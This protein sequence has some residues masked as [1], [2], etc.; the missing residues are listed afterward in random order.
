M[1]HSITNCSHYAGPYIPMTH[2]RSN[3]MFIPFDPLPS[4]RLPSTPNPTPLAAT[5][6]FS[7]CELGG[8]GFSDSTYK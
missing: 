2:L 6:L 7:V 8:G 3:W 5:N 4:F 1:Q